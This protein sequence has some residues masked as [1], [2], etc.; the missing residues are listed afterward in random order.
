MTI[1]LAAAML[2]AACASLP[3]VAQAQDA[4]TARTLID[5]AEIND[6]L[7]RYYNNFG[8]GG[9]SFASFYADD[10]EL[11][12]GTK[13]FKGKEGIESAYARPANAPPTPQRNSFS[14]NVLPTNLLF[15]VHGDTATARLTFTEVVIDKQGDAPRILTQGREFDHFVKVKG[16]WRI[17][18]RQILGANQVPDG[19]KE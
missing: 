9:Q 15:V 1:K 19:W 8:A 16:Q 4:I 7:M 10:A 13:S 12:L 6:L 3:V 2:A 14:F 18:K 11:V 17:S 5:R